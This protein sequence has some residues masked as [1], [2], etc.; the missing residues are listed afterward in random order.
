VHILCIPLLEIV[1]AVFYKTQ[2]SNAISKISYIE[3]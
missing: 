2:T 1:L 3:F